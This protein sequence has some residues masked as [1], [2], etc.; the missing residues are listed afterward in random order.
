MVILLDSNL[1]TVLVVGAVDPR[2]VPRHRRTRA[3]NEH[4]H[5]LLLTAIKAGGGDL[6]LCPNVVSE[7]S[8]LLRYDDEGGQLA[9]TLRLIVAAAIELY[10]P[11]ETAVARA[12]YAWLGVTD[13]VLLALGGG[14]ATL[15]TTDARLYAA[16]ATAALPAISFDHLRAAL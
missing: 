3:Y 6:I 14:R 10:I 12:E 8:N 4:D 1:L 5:D 9:A 15:L 2:R 11:S 13:A 7:A 16:A